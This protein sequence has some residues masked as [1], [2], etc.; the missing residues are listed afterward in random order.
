[1][2]DLIQEQTIQGWLELDRK[3]KRR[4]I[5][6]REGKLFWYKT[7]TEAKYGGFI[8]L[9]RCSNIIPMH[10]RGIE[11]KVIGFTINAYDKKHVF[12]TK[13]EE[14]GKWIESLNIYMSNILGRGT[15]R[16]H[17][18]A[19]PVRETI[20]EMEYEEELKEEFSAEKCEQLISDAYQLC[21]DWYHT[22]RTFL[23]G[24]KIIHKV[25]GVIMHNWDEFGIEYAVTGSAMVTVYNVR[26]VPDNDLEFA[27]IPHLQIS[28]IEAVNEHASNAQKSKLPKFMKKTV[29]TIRPG[30]ANVMNVLNIECKD[31]RRLRL[32]FP[33]ENPGSPR[34]TDSQVVEEFMGQMHVAFPYS[35]NALF[36]FRFRQQRDE[37]RSNIIEK[38][39]RAMSVEPSE[40]VRQR[41]AA[42][43]EDLEAEEDGW[44]AYSVV[45]EFRRIGVPNEQW[46][47]TNAN[48][49]YRLCKTYPEQLVIPSSVTI[50]DVKKVAN[51]R[52]LGRIPALTWRH[53][54]KALNSVIVRCSQPRVGLTNERSVEDEAMCQAIGVGMQGKLYV[55]D[56]RPKVNAMANQAKGSGYENMA[57]YKNMTLKFLGIDN[58]HVVRSS[59]LKLQAL[60]QPKTLKKR[61]EYH[62]WLMSIESTGWL[63]LIRK[64]L[65]GARRI[66]ELVEKGN[67]VIIHCSDGWDRTSQLSAL[68]ELM[69]DPY[70]RTIRGFQVLIE[71]DWLSFGHKFAERC[72]HL[73]YE[74]DKE[75]SPIFLQFMDVVFQIVRQF[76]FAF[77]FN[78]VYLIEILDHVNS[79]LFGTF[80]C[81]SI[82][83][84]EQSSLF[85]DT[86]SLWT[87]INH[88]ANSHR[89]VNSSYQS[90]FGMSDPK[91]CHIVDFIDPSTSQPHIVLW[92]E[93]YFR[94]NKHLILPVERG[95]KLNEVSERIKSNYFGLEAAVKYLLQDPSNV[96]ATQLQEL[97]DRYLNDTFLYADLTPTRHLDDG[98]NDSEDDALSDQDSLNDSP[99]IAD[100]SADS[101]PQLGLSQSLFSLTDQG[102]LKQGFLLKKGGNRHNWKSRWF[103]CTPHYVCYFKKQTDQ[104]PCGQ[105]SLEGAKIGTSNRKANCF[106]IHTVQRTYFISA[107][108]EAE[109][110]EWMKVLNDVTEK[111]RISV[112]SV[113]SSE[114]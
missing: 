80:L 41:L 53:P 31:G 67:S 54:N 13:E 78:T 36:A 113:A 87:F 89:F 61:K 26:F 104:K 19:T 57:Q 29:P 3:G 18:R 69:L 77:E 62:G 81:N 12:Y 20:L 66:A 111:F 108:T 4:W 83:E 55:M 103:I 106:A 110:D 34:E 94:Y 95:N 59:L 1:M 93:Y 48:C 76:P 74:L 100:V 86:Y 32:T 79:G 24:E 2:E 25:N 44:T 11:R 5:V 68:A 91:E 22:P 38:M 39:T 6:I 109:R 43:R 90:P 37:C 16:R 17:T 92:E 85:Q 98:E 40:D 97:Y 64:I 65:K 8:D 60:C 21:S 42:M 10:E 51:F 45:D 114:T 30:N 56:A 107:T 58:I 33:L 23:T 99:Q 52:S 15:I 28:K 102:I 27:V 96:D 50:E 14:A 84:R 7:Q 49:E 105:V 71:K 112:I 70:F 82:H 73:S 35:V 72:G 9:Y 46:K 101:S 88:H 47:F 63:T 75:Y